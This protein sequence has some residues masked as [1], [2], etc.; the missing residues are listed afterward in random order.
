MTAPLELTATH[1]HLYPGARGHAGA[2]LRDGAVV[3]TFSDGTRVTGHLSGDR[4][5]LAAHRTAKGADIP[6]KTWMIAPFPP[7]PDGRVPFRIAARA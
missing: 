6:E 2:P 4:L 3:L 7:G 1:S 5:T